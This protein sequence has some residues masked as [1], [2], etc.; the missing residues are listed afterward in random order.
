MCC[1][2]RAAAGPPAVSGRAAPTWLL[3]LATAYQSN[4]AMG[5]GLPPQP[6]FPG[7]RKAGM[8]RRAA[9]PKRRRSPSDRFDDLA[10]R[11]LRE[12]LSRGDAHV[13]E[14]SGPENKGGRCRVVRKLGDG[15]EVVGSHRQVE[16]TQL[17]T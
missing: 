6:E 5:C 12:C 3:H 16:I 15:D 4:G 1:P 7:A 8:I 2:L 11:T 13:A 17:P 10:V 14:N 9:T